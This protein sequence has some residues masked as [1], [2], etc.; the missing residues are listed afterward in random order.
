MSVVRNRSRIAPDF[1]GRMRSACCGLEFETSP[2][3]TPARIAERV[4]VCG[5]AA[6]EQVA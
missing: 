4:A 5:R 1:W 6:G 3:G 2:G